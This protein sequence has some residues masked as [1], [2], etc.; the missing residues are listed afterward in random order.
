TTSGKIK[1]YDCLKRFA[2]GSLDTI[3]TKNTAS[4]QVKDIATDVRIDPGKDSII[5]KTDIKIFLKELLSEMT[6]V[7]IA[8][9]CTGESLLSYGVDSI[10]VVRAAH[11][12]SEFLKVPIGAIDI[13]TATCIEELADFAYDQLNKSGLHSCGDVPINKAKQKKTT[14]VEPCSTQKLQIWL[15]QLVAVGYVCFMLVLPA[16]ISN[17]FFKSWICKGGDF[18]DY[19]MVLLLAPLS[20]ML[21]ISSTCVCIAILGTPFLQPNY[22]LNPEV[23]IWTVEFVKWW[24]LSKVQEIASKNL[25]I[26]LRGTIFLNLWFKILGA[27]ISTTSLIDTV[28]IT[29][30][31]LVSIGENT[32]VAEGAMLQ[33][34][35]VKNGILSFSAIKIGNRC[36]IGP[37]ASLQSG[38]V[39]DDEDE[40]HSLTSSNAQRKSHSQME[41]V[42]RHNNTPH[43]YAPIAHLFGIWATG[44]MGSLSAA[45]VYILYIWLFHK[46]QP[47]IQE[48]AFACAFGAYHWL[49]YAVVAYLAI[50]DSI[51]S[52][53]VNFAIHVAIGYTAYGVILGLLTGSLRYCVSTRGV[54]R[55]SKLSLL[56][57]W[58]LRRI[59][60]ASHT[61]FA[62]F[63]SGT[64]AFSWYLGFMGAKIGKHCSIRAI[65]AVS[66]PE[67]LSIG[68]GVH[69]GDFSRIVPGY[70][71]LDGYISGEV[72]V[73]E[74]SVIGSQGLILPGSVLEKDVILGAL[75]V[76]P[77]NTVLQ[78]GGVFVGAPK[79]VM[80]NNGNFREFDERIGEMDT[81]YKK[82]LGNLAA[83]FAG[84]TL[85]VNSRY[86]HRIGASGRGTLRLYNKLPQLPDHDIFSPDKS[87]P[88]IMRHSN[89]L[90][91]DDDA[92]LDPR[93]AAIR[94]LSDGGDVKSSLLDLTLKT[95]NA[96]HTRTIGD[97]AAWL[98]CGTA[99]RE[100]YVKH[101]P[102]IRDAMW[103]SLRKLDSYTELHYYSNIS[104]LFRFKDGKEMYAKFKLRPC[105]E[106]F[107]EDTGKVEPTGVLP[108]ETGT[109]PRDESD[110]RP[111]LFLADDFQKRVLSPDRVRYVL[112][113]QIRPIPSDEAKREVIL[114]CTKPWDESEFPHFDIGEI[115]IDQLLTEEESESLEFNPFLR[116]HEV[117]VI[118][119]TSCNQSASL[120]H[121]RSV[122]YEIC[123]H[124]RNKKPLPES[125]K[126]F[127]EQS[128]VKVNLSG[129]PM[130]AR[131]ETNT[132]KEV[133]LT[134]PWH[135]TLWLMSLQ[136]LLQ[137]FLPYFLCSL[138]IYFPM[139]FTSHM[140]QSRDLQ[141]H[142]LL[143]F[144]WLSSGILFGILCAVSKWILVGKKRAGKFEAIWSVSTF[145]DTTWQAIR[146]LADDYFLGMCG[147][148]VI[149]NLWMKL[150]GSSLA[151]DKGV[152]IDS[153]GA[154]LNPELVEIEDYGSIGREA[155]LF[156]HIYEGEGGRVKYGKVTIKKGGSMGSRAMAMPGATVGVGG[157]LGALSL[158][159]KEELV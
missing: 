71:S 129:C 151:W 65:N 43:H 109:V 24:A 16:Y 30:P 72:R 111:K 48:F 147:G 4:I 47:A 56:L 18:L 15:L 121:G 138:V 126:R 11:K 23:S 149:F 157:S 106:K 140:N 28:D 13:F 110:E 70:Y 35:G 145:M 19:V 12:L 156:G 60:V 74:N 84:S 87:Y 114:D 134:R 96:F 6:G 22:A 75:S 62:K 141:L 142:T 81:Q 64:E 150:M 113:L 79:A 77:E 73:H 83:N 1:R 36:S 2:D 139:K 103:G 63:L 122:V 132:T 34:H 116:C 143:P 40:V 59:V 8:K 148:S 91:S 86:F 124:L 37:Y 61:R 57:S 88:I 76:A 137:I 10:G 38:T 21:C 152:Y 107:G 45:I 115:V 78:R 159:M 52:N 39:V 41:K 44:C 101:A 158:A 144:F 82:V 123:Q 94:I 127:L 68:D 54:V 99:A 50:L 58:F 97:F 108:P 136:P 120:D 51:P 95:G 80:V 125:W 118:R 20:W 135:V 98:V 119:A 31:S 25:A 133:T 32:V 29:D 155:L 92:R 89:C 26:H 14:T 53:S 100:E 3:D 128:D 146:T 46:Q 42:R 130:A 117:D 105:D 9:I 69:L 67:L 153:Q 102:H 85:K 55:K 131:I 93:G 49:P 27:K 5:T 33:S 112:Q 7:S 66:D 90:S 104:R 17:S 154:A